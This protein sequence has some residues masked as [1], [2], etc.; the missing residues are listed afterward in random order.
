MFISHFPGSISTPGS[1]SFTIL[2]C[3]AIDMSYC[4]YVLFARHYFLL[5]IMICIAPYMNTRIP[6]KSTEMI[7]PLSMMLY[8][9][10][11]LTPENNNKTNA[12]PM[13]VLNN[14]KISPIISII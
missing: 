1:R 9:L 6:T 14:M 2:P 7:E 3:P 8:S 5:E 13:T 4:F 10:V 11:R 12:L